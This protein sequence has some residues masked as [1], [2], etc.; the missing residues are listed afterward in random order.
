MLEPSAQV[1]S[2]QHQQENL[3]KQIR[4]ARD[5]AAE[6]EK[7]QAAVQMYTQQLDAIEEQ[8]K[9][10]EHDFVLLV[11]T[12]DNLNA[13]TTEL[14]KP[15]LEQ[16][17]SFESNAP[18]TEDLKRRKQHLK[19]QTAKLQAKAEDKHKNA[20]QQ[21]DLVGR[22]NN[23]IAQN[24]AVLADLLSRYEQPQ[25]IDQAVEDIKSLEKI[26]QTVIGLPL[27]EVNDKSVREQLS[28][29]VEPLHIEANVSFF[30]EM[31]IKLRLTYPRF[32]SKYPFN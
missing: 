26:R 2:L 3:D 20:V 17:R 27:D 9:K 1:D 6:D 8:L 28:S 29:R 11:P 4:K 15:V 5:A 14:L 12:V 21:D 24:E 25:P 7:H 32:S 19:K 18:P 13:F 23:E 10:A 16:Y 30:I 31:Q 22:L